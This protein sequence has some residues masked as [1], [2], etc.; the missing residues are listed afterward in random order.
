VTQLKG[1][2]V[3]GFKLDERLQAD[4]FHL[5]KMELCELLMM[6]DCRWPWLILV[7][8]F[9]GLQE[10]HQ[11]AKTD[12]ITLTEETSR[13]SSILAEISG[14]EKINTGAL[15]NIVRQLHIH[16]IARNPGDANWPGPVWGFDK[17]QPYD[18][19][20]RQHMIDEIRKKLI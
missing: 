3:P 7:P 13:I 9:T 6:N 15:G 4:C 12:Q 14:C 2:F 5:Q 10:I 19:E 8:R 18:D 16:I 1:E 11:M 20:R 17:R